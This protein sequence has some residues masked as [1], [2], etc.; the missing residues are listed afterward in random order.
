M[1]DDFIDVILRAMHAGQDEVI[2][3]VP[4]DYDTNFVNLD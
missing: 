1:R 4:R 2:P 3:D